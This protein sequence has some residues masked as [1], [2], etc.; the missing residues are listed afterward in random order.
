MC[1]SKRVLQHGGVDVP[2]SYIAQ[3]GEWGRGEIISQLSVSQDFPSVNP[4]L[5]SL[6]EMV[7]MREEDKDGETVTDERGERERNHK[8]DRN[9]EAEGKEAEEEIRDEEENTH[10]SWEIK[11]KK[12]N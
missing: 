6:R 11:S 8:W 2:S 3:S 7:R 4:Y 12:S 9:L 1:S 10:K 5:S